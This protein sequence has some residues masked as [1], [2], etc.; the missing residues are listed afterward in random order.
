MQCSVRTIESAQIVQATQLSKGLRVGNNVARNAVGVI[1]GE[2]AEDFKFMKE[3]RAKERATKEPQR[4]DY[5]V[6]QLEEAGHTVKVIDHQ[7][8]KVNG[9]ITLWVYTGW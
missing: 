6:K 1:M 8:V 4:L 2:L 7:T 5:A 3:A 9:K